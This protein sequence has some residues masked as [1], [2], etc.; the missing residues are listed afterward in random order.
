MFHLALN[1]LM[2][3]VIAS[4]ST[5]LLSILLG[6]SSKYSKSRIINLSNRFAS[7]G[8]STP[9]AVIAMGALILVGYISNAFN[10]VLSG[11][12]F[13][14]FFAYIVRFLAVAYQ[15]IESGFEKNCEELND[16]SKTLGSTPLKSLFRVN[17][18]LIKNTIIAAGLLV[19]V[20]ATKELPLTLILR[21]FN[22]ETL[23]TATFDLS[24]QAQII[25]SSIP[26]LFIIFLTLIPIIYLNSRIGEGR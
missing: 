16:A 26:S 18:P 12:M 11:T 5:V 3:A 13:L 22:F 20:D 21:P 1:T 24:N 15:P 19:F 2:I 6:F 14:L 25:E 9:G 23:A 4:I 8:Y 7:M 17:L 10:I